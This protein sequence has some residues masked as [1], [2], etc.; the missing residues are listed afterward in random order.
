MEYIGCIIYSFVSR[1]DRAEKAASKAK[2]EK[3]LKRK[4][5]TAKNTYAF[6]YDGHN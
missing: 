4:G 6:V 5:I 2:E 3:E 1:E